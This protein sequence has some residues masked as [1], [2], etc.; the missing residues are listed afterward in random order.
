MYSEK[1]ALCKLYLPIFW[2]AQH[3]PHIYAWMSYNNYTAVDIKFK[4]LYYYR[5][6]QGS[7]IGDTHYVAVIET[8]FVLSLDQCL[9]ERTF[10][11]VIRIVK[12][13]TG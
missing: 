5:C 10:V 8:S 9:I 6:M 13:G 11:L 2:S 1:I 4:S 12:S 7:S 3:K